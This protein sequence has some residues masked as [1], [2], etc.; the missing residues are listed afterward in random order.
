M[1]DLDREAIARGAEPECDCD[2]CL[3]IYEIL[4]AA[5]GPVR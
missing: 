5:K 4:I 2:D 3:A 1:T